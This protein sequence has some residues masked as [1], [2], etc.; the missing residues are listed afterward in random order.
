MDRLRHSLLR[1]LS[2]GHRGLLV[3]H[4]LSNGSEEN[5]EVPCGSL[6][7]KCVLP[8]LHHDR[9]ALPPNKQAHFDY[10][11]DSLPCLLLSWPRSSRW[12]G[13]SCTI[14]FNKT[15]MFLGGSVPSLGN[16][17]PQNLECSDGKH[18]FPKWVTRSK[19]K[20]SYSY[21]YYAVPTSIYS[22]FFDNTTSCN[23]HWF[24]VRTSSASWHQSCTF[25]RTVHSTARPEVSGY[26][27]MWSLLNL[28]CYKVDSAIMILQ[29][30]SIIMR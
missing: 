12:L 3:A 6:G 13:G 16:T 18:R 30:V 7:A 2:S 8:W 26:C 15:H 14:K 10:G 4:V 20:Q 27:S 25:T 17:D 28:W 19:G 22:S 23:C 9:A 5:Q 24:K 21:F 1:G 29:Y 11:S